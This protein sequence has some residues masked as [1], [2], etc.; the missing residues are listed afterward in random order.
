MKILLLTLV[1]LCLA[2]S[3]P[4]QDSAD[5]PPSPKRTAA[6]LAELLGPIA[7][8]PDALIAL[9]L[10]AST[11]PSDI[12]L[13][14][15]FIVAGENLARVEDKSWDSSVKALIR[16]PDTLKWLDENLEWTAQVGDA[17]VQ[18]PVEVLESIQQLRAKA[19][20]LGNLNDTPQQKIVQDDTYIRIIPAEADYIY[21]PRY[22]PEVIY[23]DRPQA[24][25]LL[26]F[27]TG[28]GTGSWLNYDLDWHRHR[29]YRGDWNKGWDYSRDRDRR[30]REDYSY[31]NNN[32]TNSREWHP[33]I[34][35]RRTQSRHMS[36][37]PKS[38]TSSLSH[39][40]SRDLGVDEYRDHHKGIARPMPI[41]GAPHHRET[42]KRAESADGRNPE[43]Q[44]DPRTTHDPNSRDDHVGT[45]PNPKTHPHGVTNEIG[46]GRDGRDQVD[47][48]NKSEIQQGDHSN[49]RG[50]AEK[51]PRVDDPPKHKSTR[52]EE[53]Q[54]REAP[55]HDEP[56]K[57]DTT[58]QDA[59]SKRQDTPKREDVPK[60]QDTTKHDE[61]KHKDVPKHVDTPKRDAP[62]QEAAKPH[63]E[64]SS[65][66][67]KKNDKRKDD[68]KDKDKKKD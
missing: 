17:F 50:N 62:K 29:L 1:G 21:E 39:T 48:K 38:S 58:K 43:R 9:I 28:Y 56:R 10:P 45:V 64:P 34:D 46:N 63:D 53:P 65:D 20:V 49:S 24:S 47:H 27:S 52:V 42:V 30:D 8:Y 14:A 41:A 12:V 22:D 7:L 32:L 55:K 44:F 23:Y 35:R 31:I 33:D 51:K 36:E 2:T 3:L 40:G 25:P 57:R 26:M 4:A 37:R 5:S 19:R 6:E 15:R 16:Y 67:R 60:H 11:Y 61:P 68:D 66:K 59:P 13:G 18:Q 54:P